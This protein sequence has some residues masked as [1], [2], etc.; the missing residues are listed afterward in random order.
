MR[1]ALNEGARGIAPNGFEV[2]REEAPAT[3]ATS[4]LGARRTAPSR[5]TVAQRRP[6]RGPARERPAAP[7]AARSTPAPR[8]RGGRRALLVLL[9][10]ALIAGAT[11]A[12]IVLT[13]PAPTRVVLRTVVYSDIHKSAEALKELVSENTQ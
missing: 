4:V 8:P 1:R 6:R 10:L 5:G 13:A 12:A 2:V 3:H 7:A 9:V 11:V